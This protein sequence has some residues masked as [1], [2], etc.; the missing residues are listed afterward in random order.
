MKLTQS[1]LPSLLCAGLLSLVAI[2]AAKAGGFS[3]GS[4]DIDTLFEEENFDLRV[5]ARAVVPTQK[6]TV[7]ANPALVGT[8]FYE[9]YLVP[10][11]ALKF[12]LSQNLRCEGTFT[13]SNGASLEYAAPKIPT[14]TTSEVFTTNEF[15]GAC[16]VR[17]DA[18]PGVFS[19]I[20]GVFAEDLDYHRTTDLSIPTAGLL[21]AGTPAILN[22]DGQE[23]GWRAGL[24]YEIPEIK[25]RAEILYRSGTD[26]GATGTLTVPGALVHSPAAF[27]NLPATAEGHLPQSVEFMVRSGVAPTWLVFTDVKWSDWSVQKALIVTSPIGVTA[28]QY[29][30]RDGWTVTGGVVHSFGD[31]FAGQVSLT[32]DQGVGTGWNITGAGDIWTLAIGGRLRGPKGGEFR[33][34]IGLSYLDSVTETQY[35]NAI[36]PGNIRSGFNSATDDGFAATFAFGYIVQW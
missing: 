2:G 19:L 34:G 12:N 23:Y 14:G 5:E 13:E 15:G 9:N 28:D 22:L 6:F 17:F 31:Q 3:R 16:L 30:W 35:A 25:A 32:W 33:G 27:V 36:I 11:A 10:S 8:N 18:G 20:G 29:N 4:A 24:A 26:Y 21:P 7:N 1:P